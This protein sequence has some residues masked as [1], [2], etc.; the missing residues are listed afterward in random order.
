MVP[1]KYIIPAPLNELTAQDIDG[2]ERILTPGYVQGL[3]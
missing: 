1:S 3:G 2:Q